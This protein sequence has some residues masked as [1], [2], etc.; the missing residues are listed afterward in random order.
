MLFDVACL[1]L[2]SLFLSS[3]ALEHLTCL[4]LKFEGDVALQ[5]ANPFVVAFEEGTILFGVGGQRLKCCA[6][7]ALLIVNE[8]LG[9]VV[10]HK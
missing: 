2:D 4:N 10:A 8:L 6:S 7:V 5:I 9:H 3:G 1:V